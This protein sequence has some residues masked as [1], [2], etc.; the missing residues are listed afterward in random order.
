MSGAAA[1]IFRSA[2]KKAK[3]CLQNIQRHDFSLNTTLFVH[4]S[5]NAKIRQ[6]AQNTQYPEEWL[7]PAERTFMFHADSSACCNNVF[8][9]TPLSMCG[10]YDRGCT[11]DANFG[12]CEGP[13]WVPDLSSGSNPSDFTGCTNHP[14]YPAGW[15]GTKNFEFDSYGECCRA[16]HDEGTMMCSVRDGCTGRVAQ[17]EVTGVPTR[18][19]TPPPTRKVSFSKNCVENCIFSIY[20]FA[21]YEQPPQSVHLKERSCLLRSCFFTIIL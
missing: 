10:V 5:I 11:I 15:K 20:V 16:Y 14:D 1:L 6:T 18:R 3:D 19:P 8:P 4:F 2:M 7:R 9:G 12:S 17:V 13:K 21:Q